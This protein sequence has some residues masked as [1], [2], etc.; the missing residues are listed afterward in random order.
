MDDFIVRDSS[1]IGNDGRALGELEENRLGNKTV[2]RSQE[3]WDIVV[4]MVSQS[5]TSRTP[6]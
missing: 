1:D 4:A 2:G 6:R 5:D 3:S